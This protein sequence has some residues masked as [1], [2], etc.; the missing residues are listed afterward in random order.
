MSTNPV[1]ESLKTALADTYALYLKTQNYH[2]N[3]TG[4]NFKTLHLLFEEQYNDLALAVDTIAERI[5]ALGTKAPGTWKA[6]AA[7]TTIKDGDENAD[8]TSMVQELAN[9]QALV[10]AS[11]QQTLKAAQNTGDEVS[12]GVVVERMSVHEKAAWMLNSSL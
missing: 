1:A 3:V 7:V 9:D 5:R 10:I 2:W 11:L 4:P 6:Y 8:A 12:I